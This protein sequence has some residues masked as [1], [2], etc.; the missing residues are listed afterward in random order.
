MPAEV[1]VELFEAVEDF[2]R[3]ALGQQR[4]EVVERGLAFGQRALALGELGRSGFGEAERDRGGG[5][6]GA[7]PGREGDPAVEGG[8]DFGPI[9]RAVAARERSAVELAAQAH[10]QRRD[11]LHRGDFDPLAAAGMHAFEQRGDRADGRERA[12]GA[13][14]DR[15][16][17]GERLLVGVA[18]GVGEAGQSLDHEVVGPPIGVGAGS[19]EGR[20]V[21]DDEPGP[22]GLQGGGIERAEF[23]GRG[24]GDEEVG[25]AELLEQVVFACDALR[26]L[27]VAERGPEQRVALAVPLDHGRVSAQGRA[28]GVF[29]REHVGAP[30]GEFASAGGRFDAAAPF[31]DAQPG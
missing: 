29:E 27:A 12:D 16:R 19:A 14:H 24:V 8:Q 10:D 21:D 11:G 13:R 20:V 7:V 31:D 2:F 5:E 18:V 23:A 25:R 4:G 28:G 1:D 15:A 30:A 9:G 22:T 26:A 3:A 17:R 6:G